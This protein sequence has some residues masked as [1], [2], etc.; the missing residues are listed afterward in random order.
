M[1]LWSLFPSFC[2]APRDIVASFNRSLGEL[3]V[4][5]ITD[6]RYGVVCVHAARPAMRPRECD[7]RRVQSPP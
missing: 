5:A 3:L 6:T 4:K 2:V 7:R 1:L